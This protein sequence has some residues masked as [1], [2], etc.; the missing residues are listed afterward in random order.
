MTPAGSATTVHVLRQ[1]PHNHCR[2]EL[3]GQLV[4]QENDPIFRWSDCQ[5]TERRSA[6]HDEAAFV[7]A[8]PGLRDAPIVAVTA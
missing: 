6:T 1:T 2:P 7:V 3:R 5:S 8:G 4:H